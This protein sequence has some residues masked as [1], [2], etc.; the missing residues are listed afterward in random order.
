MTAASGTWDSADRRDIR[1]P[2]E[3]V[4]AVTPSN[5]VD[6]TTPSRGIYVGV[7]G[8]V[9]VDMAGAG[10][11][12]TIGNLAAGMWHPMRVTRIYATGTAATGILAGW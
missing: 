12:V 7:S 11:N 6:L 8:D 5:S 4:V 9:T 10:E 3:N 2:V 1:D